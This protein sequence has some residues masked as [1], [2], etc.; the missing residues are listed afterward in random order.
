MSQNIF[1][2]K[3]RVG[4]LRKLNTDSAV[5]YQFTADIICNGSEKEETI[6][7]YTSREGSEIFRINGKS[8][9][10]LP[11]GQNDW[12]FVRDNCSHLNTEHPNGQK[13]RSEED[14][15]FK[16]FMKRAAEYEKL[17]RELLFQRNMNQ[18]GGRPRK[19][20]TAK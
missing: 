6:R 7:F 8:K 1:E 9:P 13:C 3:P 4:T 15:I 16:L 10:E 2:M 20:Q 19:H 11:V 18:A 12:A 14:H 5:L 17:Y